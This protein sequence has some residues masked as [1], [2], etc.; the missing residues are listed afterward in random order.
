MRVTLVLFLGGMLA[1][2]YLIAGVF[3]LRY[4]RRTRERLFASFAIALF[5]LA[6]QRVLLAANLAIIEDDTWYYA[7]RLLAFVL[8][9][10]AIVD[11]NRAE[12]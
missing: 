7:L 2:G 11:K 12:R 8:I 5:I 4:W 1:M 10:W 9:L 3:F 6:L